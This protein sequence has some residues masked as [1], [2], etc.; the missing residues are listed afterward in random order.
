MKKEEAQPQL[1]Q[2]NILLSVYY[3]PRAELLIRLTLS[4]T[5]RGPHYSHL[6]F[7]SDNPEA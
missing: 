7:A 6:H 5:P 4:A 1:Q 2:F 3:K